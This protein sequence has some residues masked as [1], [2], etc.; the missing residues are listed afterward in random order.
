VKVAILGTR[1][2]PALYGGFET[3]V[4]EIGS[5]LAER[6]YDV[7]VYCRNPGQ[8][9][10]SYAGMRLVNL[11]AVRHRVAETLSHTSFSAL[12][13]VIKDRP[14][15]A[16]VL[17]AGNA[18]LLRPL[19]A[20]GIPVAVHLDGLESKREKWRGA[21]AKYYRWA[22]R[23]SVRSGSAV[24]ADCQAIADY[25]EGTYG[26]SAWVIAYGA[27]VIEVGSDRLAEIE[28]VRRDFHL[29]VSR[30]EPENHVLEAVHGYR[31]SE[32]TRPLVVVGSAPYSKWYVDKVT[33]AA[34]GD[35]RIRFLGGMYDQ[36]LLN[37]LYGNCRTYIH[38]HSVGGT[39][40][41]LL[42]AMGA[43][44]PVLAF[45]CE[46]NRE[47][48]AERALFWSSGEDMVALMDDLA[49][50]DFDELLPELSAAGRRRIADHYQ[51][52]TVTDEYEELLDSLYL[53]R[54]GAAR[55]DDAA[56]VPR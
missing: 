19:R 27:D 28:C 46:F 45:D 3:A 24:V 16:L 17:N 18:P 2:V 44:A 54:R 50:G 20:A 25:V 35:P 38:G 23:A 4:E 10:T 13:A 39:N 30:M 7:T 53:L 34:A 9:L 8:Q 37:Q 52:D 49:D 5:R 33:E 21:G 41:S 42:R 55:D 14:D 15:V 48:T 36:E 56:V 32:E 11:P 47:V 22:E 43:G 6:G 51:W 31:L 40:P 26:R 29:V 1:G 12:H